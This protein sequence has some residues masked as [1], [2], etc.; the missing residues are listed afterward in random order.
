M[1]VKLLMLA[2]GALVQHGELEFWQAIVAGSSGA[3][4]GDQAGFFLGRSGGRT[5]VE[6]LTA[7]FRG[8][9]MLAKAERFFDRWGMG[10]IFFS[11]WLITPIGPWLNL[12]SGSARYPWLKFT[13]VGVLGE[14]LWVLIYVLLGIYFS[15]RIQALADILVN[16]GWA[17]FGLFLVSILGWKVFQFFKENSHQASAIV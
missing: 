3:I 4:L 8:A 7:R 1:P 13:V 10:A 2:V 9:E 17:I 16:L 11:R 15:D 5:V 12:I 14:T 6:R